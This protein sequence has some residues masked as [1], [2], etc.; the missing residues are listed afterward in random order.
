MRIAYGIAGVGLGHAVRSKVVIDHLQKTHDV[1]V[2][3]SSMAYDFLKG[4]KNLHKVTGTRL[5]YKDNRLRYWRTLGVNLL[6]LPAILRSVSKVGT[7][8]QQ[9][10]VK[11]VITDF[12]PVIVLA[13]KLKHIPTIAIDNIH[14]LTHTTIKQIR[15][16]GKLYSLFVTRLLTPCD[17]YFVT[18]FFLTKPVSKK[19]KVFPPLLRTELLRKRPKKEKHVVV[20]QRPENS[21]NLLEVLQSIDEQFVVYGLP[22]TKEKNVTCK[23]ISPTTFVEDLQ[24]AKAVITTGG[25]SLITEA[26]ALKKPVLSIPVKHHYEQHVNASYVAKHGYGMHTKELTRKIIKTFLTALPKYKANLSSYKRQGN[27]ELLA[28]LDKELA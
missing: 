1:A 8:L 9:K 18:S 4:M 14:A 27:K 19:V 7:Y 25:F 17:K 26:L 6:R 15:G 22:A 24:Q 20:Y 12:D 13:A 10:K 2:F 3:T 16:K 21:D 11:V 28:T 23:P 5:V